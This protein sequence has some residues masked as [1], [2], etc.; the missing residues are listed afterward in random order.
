MIHKADLLIP[1]SDGFPAIVSVEHSI[2]DCGCMA[3]V[4]A[5]ID[6]QETSVAAIPCSDAHAPMMR[7]FY[8]RMAESL[9]HPQDRLLIDVVDDLMTTVEREERD[10]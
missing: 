1:P 9:D 6:N 10:D 8:D 4:G 3:V 7:R 2:L 5:R